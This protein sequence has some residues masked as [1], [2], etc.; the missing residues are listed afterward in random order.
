[1]L[2]EQQSPAD[3]RSSEGQP[4]QRRLQP[5]QRGSLLPLTLPPPPPSSA[6]APAACSARLRCERFLFRKLDLCLF[7]GTLSLVNKLEGLRIVV[8]IAEG[9]EGEAGKIPRGAARIS[10]LLGWRWEAG[11]NLLAI[12]MR[13]QWPSEPLQSHVLTVVG[14]AGEECIL[15]FAAG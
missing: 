12:S 8:R 15:D 6:E 2:S 13:V 3:H 1:M 4:S 5:P 10:C 14:N 9:L 7:G 11:L